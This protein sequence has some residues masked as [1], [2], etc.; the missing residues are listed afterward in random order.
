MKLRE[1]GEDEVVRRLI[2]SLPVNRRALVKA[3]DDCAVVR[4]S[5][6]VQLLKADCIVEGIH[7]FAD[8]D[9]KR[10]GW[11][12]LCRAISDIGAMGGKPLDAVVTVALSRETEF[13]WLNSVYAGIRSAAKRYGLSLVGGETAQSPGPVFISVALTGM[14]TDG[15]YV[16]RSGGRNLDCLYVTG[17]LGGSL[18]GK[19]LRFH[20]RLLEGQWLIRK[21]PISA[22]MDLSDGLA[23]DL[24][25]MASASKLGFEVDLAEL[26]R[27]TE[28]TVEQALRDGEDYELLFAI[29]PGS[30]KRLEVAWRKQFPRLALT[31]VGRLVKGGATSFSAKGYD[32]FRQ[33][34]S[35]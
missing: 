35:S 14:P 5:G 7:F 17:K 15:K 28:C 20:P 25:R 9:P 10:I 21:F 22:M 11:K 2:R 27:N 18:R 24:P 8:A 12:A 1:L 3:G 31:C 26:P 33:P 32:H 19:H 4:V 23:T 30:A 29:A 6:G 13:S 16:T 34:E